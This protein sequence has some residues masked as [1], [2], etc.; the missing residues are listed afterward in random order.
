MFNPVTV[1]A[2]LFIRKLDWDQILDENLCNEWETIVY[3]LIRLFEISFPRYVGLN[4]TTIELHCFTDAS[5][6][7]YGT[8]VYIRIVQAGLIKTKLMFSKCHLAPKSKTLI[9]IPRLELLGV[10]IGTRALKF[11]EN[12][13]GKELSNRILWTDS[14]CVL[15]WLNSKK[16]LPKFVERRVKEINKHKET[17]RFYWEIRD[18]STGQ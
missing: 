7:V 14:Q 3:Y 5:K 2:K 11:V 6:D 10:L 15:H 12:S 17:P 8:A 1:K 4:H 13:L 9:T 18:L 16:I